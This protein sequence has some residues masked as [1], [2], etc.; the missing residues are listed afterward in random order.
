MNAVTALAPDVPAIG[1]FKLSGT[2][3]LAC[4]DRNGPWPQG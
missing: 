4:G 1:S 3:T 2:L